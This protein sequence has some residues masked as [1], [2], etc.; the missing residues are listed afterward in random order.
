MVV[1]VVIRRSL[2]RQFHSAGPEKENAHSVDLYAVWISCRRCCLLNADQVDDSL[3]LASSPVQR[4]AVT[5]TNAP[6]LFVTLQT[7]NTSDDK[8]KFMPNKKLG[9]HRES[10]RCIVLS[11]ISLRHSRSLKVIRNETLEYGV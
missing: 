9:C 2:S 6:H 3:P 4:D 7:H 1:S 11:N 8:S 5:S 10:A